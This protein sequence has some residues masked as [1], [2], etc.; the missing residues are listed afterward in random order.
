MTLMESTNS[1]LDKCSVKANLSI[2]ISAKNSLSNIGQRKKVFSFIST[3]YG[4]VVNKIKKS[5]CG[6]I[7]VVE[8]E[9]CLGILFQCVLIGK[10]SEAKIISSFFYLFHCLIA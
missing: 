5:F 2:I 7:L 6:I 10:L 8:L 1:K 3:I 9:D 4:V